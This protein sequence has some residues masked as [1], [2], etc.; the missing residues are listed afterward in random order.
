MPHSAIKNKNFSFNPDGSLNQFGLKSIIQEISPKLLRPAVKYT[1]MIASEHATASAQMCI[2]KSLQNIAD[3][4]GISKDTARRHLRQLTEMGILHK[5]FV[6]DKQTGKQKPCLYTYTP[7]FIRIAKGFRRYA[8]KLKSRRQQDFKS[9]RSRF[10]ILLESLVFRAKI[11]LSS[12]KNK[13][14]SKGYPSKTALKQGWQNTTQEGGKTAPNKVFV[15]QV[16]K[17]PA[18]DIS[19]NH[20]SDTA[21]KCHSGRTSQNHKNGAVH[22][23]QDIL[24]RFSAM[25]NKRN[26]H[27]NK[28]TKHFKLEQSEHGKQ[29]AK[30]AQSRPE[31][32]ISEGFNHARYREANRVADEAWKE[33]DRISRQSSPEKTAAHLANLRALL[34]NAQAKKAGK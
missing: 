8:D 29:P 2:F 21:E 11:G 19:Q 17:Y 16:N 22:F 9:A 4:C 25:S 26:D 1:L 28:T 18:G 30:P 12:L 34:N 3:E 33:R 32:A 6:I 15:D 27:K 31:Q 10:N 7:L 13:I 24:E 20:A 14:F 23:F 5:Q